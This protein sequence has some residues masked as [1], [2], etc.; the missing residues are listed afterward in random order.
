M[1]K[2]TRSRVL[3]QLYTRSV[4]DMEEKTGFQQSIFSS[5][6]DVEPK[7]ESDEVSVET[8]ETV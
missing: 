4:P 1:F 3:A 8:S 7:D 2:G 5:E 6:I